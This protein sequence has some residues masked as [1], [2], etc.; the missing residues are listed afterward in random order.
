MR[1][2]LLLIGLI[3]SSVSFAGDKQLTC[4]FFDDREQGLLDKG[5]W[6]SHKIIFNTDDFDELDPLLTLISELKVKDG[7]DVVAHMYTHEDVK[8]K[9]SPS[10]IMFTTPEDEFAPME[11]KVSRTSLK[12]IAGYTEGECS[13]DDVVRDRVF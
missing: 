4:L 9:V 10:S 11:Y 7:E 13:I 2:T 5:A 8:Y 3:V 6:K 1:T 12:I